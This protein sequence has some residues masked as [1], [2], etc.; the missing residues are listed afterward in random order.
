MEPR[1]ALGVYDRATGR[2][3]LYAGA[4]GPVVDVPGASA[5]TSA[6]RVPEVM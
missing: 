1:A 3:T 4:G 6:R 5:W 2:Y